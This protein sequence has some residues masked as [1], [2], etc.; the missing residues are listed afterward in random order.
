MGPLVFKTSVGREERPGCVRFA[1][2]SAIARK[3]R[4][5]GRFGGTLLS[6]EPH[7]MRV[8]SA[9]DLGAAAG[10]IGL[11]TAAAR[12]PGP[13][14]AARLGHGH[15]LP[16]VGLFNEKTHHTPYRFLIDWFS[17]PAVQQPLK[18]GPWSQAEP[19]HRFFPIVSQQSRRR[20]GFND[21][22][23]GSF[24][25]ASGAGLPFPAGLAK[26]HTPAVTEGTMR[27]EKHFQVCPS[28]RCQ[29]KNFKAHR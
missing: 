26:P 1:H 3:T 25:I 17:Y 16:P 24:A 21:P 14:H 10:I 9:A 4:P 29:R 12:F 11:E 20:A 13:A 15:A 23:Q 27:A 7:S 18:V 8:S 6:P 2:A 28:I 19:T 5:A 22:V